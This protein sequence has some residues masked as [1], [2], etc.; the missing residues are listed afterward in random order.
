MDQRYTR[1]IGSAAGRGSTREESRSLPALRISTADAPTS[2]RRLHSQRQVRR[3]RR[4]GMTSS[5]AVTPMARCLRGVTRRAAGGR[6]TP[7]GE[8][9]SGITTALAAVRAI[10]GM[11]PTC[12]AAARRLRCAPRLAMA[13]CTASLRTSRTPPRDLRIAADEAS[14]PTCAS[15]A[16][17]WCRT[18]RRSSDTSRSHRAGA[19][20]FR[21]WRRARGAP[22]SRR[23]SFL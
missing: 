2:R 21:E 16:R 20:R 3:S 15:A 14:R 17:S 11:L 6:V 8:R 1:E 7:T 5:P 19:A 18:V 9:W 12:R 10:H 22:C 13:S 23:R 4:R